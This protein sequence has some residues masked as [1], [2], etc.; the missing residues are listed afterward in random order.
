[1]LNA[2]F[3]DGRGRQ[4]AYYSPPPSLFFRQEQLNQPFPFLEPPK[5]GIGQGVWGLGNGGAF[6][7]SPVLQDSF[8]PKSPE[9]KIDWTVNRPLTPQSAA[10]LKQQQKIR[11]Q[12]EKSRKESLKKAEA[13]SAKADKKQA[14]PDGK[15]PIG[16]TLESK[17]GKRPEVGKNTKNKQQP[18]K[19]EKEGGFKGSASTLIGAFK[20]GSALIITGGINAFLFGVPLKTAALVSGVVAGSQSLTALK[21]HRENNEFSRKIIGFTRKLMGRENDLTPSGKEWSMVPV[22]GTVC[23]MFGLTE[24]LGNHMYT[25][26]TKTP[27]KT[28][29]Q[30]FDALTEEVEEL[31]AKKVTGPNAAFR[32]FQLDNMK[33]GKALI[34][35]LE[36]K[37]K[38]YANLDGNTLLKTG[39]I[40]ADKAL[41]RARRF[42][43]KSA[44]GRNPLLGYIWS[45]TM[46]SLGGAAQTVIAAMMQTKVD[47]AHG[48][49]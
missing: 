45:F 27:P 34:N 21:I 7:M 6:P 2:P 3:A 31:K 17:T 40:L 32:Q 22:W 28:L 9:Q 37:A 23:G 25:K 10:F 41:K 5:N 1:M 38:A 35:A 20:V 29:T 33:R 24:A 18:E 46:A 44:G 49:K 15:E 30:R 11:E 26:I 36:N 47:K 4:V 43:E 42:S 14:Q 8:G 16:Q 48:L 19:R 13:A 39:G 12:F